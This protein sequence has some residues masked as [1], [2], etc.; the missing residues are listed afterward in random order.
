M[1]VAP[2]LKVTVLGYRPVMDEVV[3][4]L[5]HAGAVEIV[6][7]P[8]EME[9]EEV[10]SDDERRRVLDE[11][12]ADAH[13]VRDFL[14]RYHVN[15][16][17]FS[18]FIMEKH[19]LT[20][21][22]F[23]AIEPDAALLEIYRQCEEISDK[24]ASL[25]RERARLKSL[26]ADLAP[27]AGVHVQ[28]SSLH[29]TQHAALFTGTVPGSDAAAIRQ[30]LRDV[31]PYVS[32]DEYGAEGTRAAWIILV[33]RCCLDDVRSALAATGF[34]EVTFPGLSN[35]PV[36]EAAIATDRIEALA[37]EEQ[38]LVERATELS[39]EYYA[40][41]VAT[42]E[43][44]DT[45]LDALMVRGNFGRTERTFVIHGWA[46]ASR[47]DDVAAALA[48]LEADLDVSFSEPQADDSPP[49]E[50]DNPWF[51]KPFETLT[52]LYGRP[53][54]RELDPTP[55]LAPFF[56][57]FF[58]ICVGDVGYGAMLMA[59]AFL[60][61]TRLD[62]APGV[63]KFMDLLMLGGG[64][65]MV[66]GALTG[67]WFALPTVPAVLLTVKVLDPLKQLTLFLIVTVA[68]GVTQVFFGVL[69]AAYDAARNGDRS[70]AIN[71]Q[72][73]TIFFF[74]MIAVA[75]AVPGASGWAIVV[76]LGVA[77]LMKGHSLEVAF[78][79]PELSVVQKAAGGVWL[80]LLVAWLA[81]VAFGGPV[82]LVFWVFLAVSVVGLAFSKGVRK[83]VVA[84]FAG[85]YGVYGLSAFIGDILSYTRLAALGLSGALVGFVFNIMSGMVWSAALPLFG[86]GVG[87]I[88]G[89]VL[90]LVIAAAIF[91]V[92]H[93]FNVVINLLGAFVHPARLQFVEFF[94]KFYEGGGRAFNPFRFHTKSVVLSAG[95]PARQEGGAA[96]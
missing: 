19:H 72:L 61:K 23:A 20:Q 71:D 14:G 47:R 37:V 1:S 44:I 66:I 8:L 57:I 7:Q 87:G 11:Y 5:Q 49:V 15:E 64:M 69:V 82:S 54:Y 46:R 42:A 38:D 34:Q 21:Q 60:I 94:S 43:A 3:D 29:G 90:V 78:S 93:V 24:L 86:K 58:G 59:G 6:A 63:K 28:I 13:F 81:M 75:A 27:W 65:A 95:R 30:T 89:G 79:D 83:G 4:A 96:S 31:S 17:P 85:L 10:P 67:S 52:D 73:S 51:I 39:D 9:S 45:G 40:R 2:M 22:E 12:S 62:V 26:V 50:L 92:G 53:S 76:G 55:I 41:S 91:L 84:F 32:V 18:A 80:G 74:V 36:E 25:E 56:L 48:P 16:Q 70:G 88:V 77:I 33:H 68:L 35:Y